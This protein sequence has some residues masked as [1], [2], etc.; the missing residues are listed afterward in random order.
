M[1]TTYQL[2]YIR[3]ASISIW[4]G[5]IICTWQLFQKIFHLR[6][7]D[8]KH[9]D[10]QAEVP[11]PSP[12]SDDLYEARDSTWKK[13][14]LSM[15]IA[16]GNFM[17]LT[18]RDETGSGGSAGTEMTTQTSADTVGGEKKNNAKREVPN[19]SFSR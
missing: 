1:T 16:A 9:A 4:I 6:T 14:F 10:I 11:T 7:F 17:G 19:E 5:N 15:Q 8:N 2:W 3:E 18:K 13:K 12:S